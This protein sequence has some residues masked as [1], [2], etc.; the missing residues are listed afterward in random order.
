MDLPTLQWM[1]ALSGIVLLAASFAIEAFTRLKHGEPTASSGTIPGVAIQLQYLAYLKTSS[2]SA[3][4]AFLSLTMW[5]FTIPIL[6]IPM[7][8]LSGSL[9]IASVIVL[10]SLSSRHLKLVMGHER[11]LT[12]RKG[13]LEVPIVLKAGSYAVF[14]FQLTGGVYGAYI[15]SLLV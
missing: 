10:I 15:V 5:S 3:A 11:L 9:F 4:M 14:G 2:G 1:C 12:M 6:G 7:I 13:D 8:I